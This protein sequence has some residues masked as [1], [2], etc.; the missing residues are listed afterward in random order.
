MSPSVVAVNAVDQPGGAEI[1]LLRLWDRLA[2]RGWHTGI[3]TPS[4]D[5]PMASSG[6]PHAKLDVGGL[7]AREG[8]RAVGSF[9]RAHRLAAKWDVIYLNS[10]V[11]GRLLPALRGARTVLHV[12][13]MV[14][15]IPRHWMHASLVLANSDAVAQRLEGLSPHVVHAPI[16][17]D[18]PHAPRPWDGDHGPVVGFVGRIEARKGVMDLV[19]AAPGIRERVPGARVVV[20]GGDPYESDPAYVAAVRASGEV[21]HVEWVENAPGVMRHFD[22]LVAPSHQEPFGMVLAEAM[23]VGTPVVATRVGGLADVVEDGVTG[24]LVEPGSPGAIADGVARVLASREAMGAAGVLAARR[25]DADAYADR[26][27]ALLKGLL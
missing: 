14:E 6:H 17:L 8:A 24:A 20:I 3:T 2:A 15:R 12:H 26:V 7:G 16:D 4:G 25:F 10:T 11:C 5:G 1:A 22:V 27:E 23:A 21:E 13:D 9:P 18:P 19:H